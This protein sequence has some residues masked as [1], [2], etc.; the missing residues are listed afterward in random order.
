MCTNYNEDDYTTVYEEPMEDS[1]DPAEENTARETGSRWRH[2]LVSG[3]AYLLGVSKEH[4]GETGEFSQ[5]I[6]EE[7]NKEKSARIV[8]N[9]CTLR[10]AILRN[11]GKINSAIYYD[12]KNLSTLPEYIPQDSLRELDEDGIRIEH[13]NYKLN[14]YT[15]DINNHL[16]NR[17]GNCRQVFPAWLNWD[18]VKELF[19]MPNG[20]KEQ[21]VI[22]ESRKYAANR[23]NYPFSVYLNWDG[24]DA[25]TLLLH[26]GR[27]V[28]KLYDAHNDYFI[29]LSKV[30]DASEK[31]KTSIYDYLKRS[32][33]TSVIVDCENSDPYKLYAVLKNLDQRELLKK[34]VNIVLFDDFHTTDAWKILEEFT[35]IPVIYKQ[36]DRVKENK[37]LVDQT[38]MITATKMA[39]KEEADSFILAASDSDYW[40]LMQELPECRFL[41]MAEYKKCGADIRAAMEQEGIYYC[42]MDDF[43]TGNIEDIKERI[44]L[45][46]LRTDVEKLVKADLNGII[47]SVILRTRLNLSEEERAAYYRKLL[48]E[49]RLDIDGEGRMMLTV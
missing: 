19:L 37:S 6:Y 12:M 48:K 8:R 38:L 26:D 41:V 34:I 45:K 35:E 40:A 15:I 42:F 32:E 14:N 25:G 7:R 24:T 46:E 23:N 36:I 28:Q 44:F 13:A 20:A 29:D 49:I 22:A 3:A 16:K 17:I 39:L 10:T 43:C 4:F 2:E 18:Y 30:R 1:K 47:N 31:T 33:R 11:S 9:L 27:F 5:E 21:G